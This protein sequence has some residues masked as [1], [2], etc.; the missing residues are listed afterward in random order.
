MI[1]CPTKV[2]KAAETPAS[3]NSPRPAK[4]SRAKQITQAQELCTAT[5]LNELMK[6]RMKVNDN[7]LHK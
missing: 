1:C 2:Y 6:Q 4:S 3:P 5:R 7:R